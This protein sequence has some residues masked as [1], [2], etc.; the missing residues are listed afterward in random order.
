MDK[1]AN[2]KLVGHLERMKEDKMPK[3]IFIQELEVTKR[4]GK[5]Q[6]RMERRSREIFKC[7]E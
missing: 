3:K 6:V 1:G 5:A 7:W 4:M 2:D